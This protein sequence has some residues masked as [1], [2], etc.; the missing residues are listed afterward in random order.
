MAATKLNFVTLDVFTSTPYLGNPLA[1][2][3]VPKSLED[4][5]SHEQ[6]LKIAN[7]FN[8]SETV[9]LH[10]NEDLDTPIRIDIYM[11]DR[12]LPFAG[13]PTVGSGWYLLQSRY[14]SRE[15]ITL[16]T[17]AGDIPVVRGNNVGKVQ[18]QVPTNFRIHQPLV[19]PRVKLLQP[20]LVAKDYLNGMDGPEPLVSIV[21]GMTFLLVEL[22]SE[23][24]LARLQPSSERITVSAIGDW[25]HFVGLYAF[26]QRADGVVRTRM[27]DG[28]LEDP[29]T[30][31]AASTLAGYLA[32]QRGEGRHVVEIL[33]GVEMG[34][35][36]EISVLVDVGVDGEISTI[37]LGGGA[38]QIME[39]SL[40]VP[41]P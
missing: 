6:K 16:R 2:V 13:H 22:T 33:Q 32:R 35:R 28:T 17:R 12:E 27:F 15:T 39:G 26:F 36:S 29:A 10:D 1:I 20:R 37:Q 7:E 3:H 4:T 30:G 23:E 40:V 25:G 19:H 14:P 8:L 21:K 9:F 11:V 5:L 31:S 34:R 41:I 38:V 24:A 18:L